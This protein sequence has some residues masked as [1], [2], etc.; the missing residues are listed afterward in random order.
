MF[1]AES[2]VNH[3][4]DSRNKKTPMDLN[5]IDYE[6]IE[7]TSNVK[8]LKM[9]Y[10]SLL[11]D[12]CFPDLMKTCGE[13]ICTIDPKFKRQMTMGKDVIPEEEKQAITAD[14]NDFFADMNKM[15]TALVNESIT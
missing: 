10:E 4:E 2:N 15:D 1:N 3:T 5:R 7:K 14:L 8:E 11:I 13:K 12:G 6:W 9:A